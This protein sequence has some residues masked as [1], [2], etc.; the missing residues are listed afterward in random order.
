NI[1]C[2]HKIKK[3]SFSKKANSQQFKAKIVQICHSPPAPTACNI[4][5]SNFKLLLH[6]VNNLKNMKSLKKADGFHKKATSFW[7]LKMQFPKKEGER[8]LIVVLGIGR[9]V[10]A[11]INLRKIYPSKCEFFGADPFS[12][13]N[14]KLFESVNGIFFR[15]AIG[16]ERKLKKAILLT[17]LFPTLLNGGLFDELD[18]HVCQ[19]SMELH[20]SMGEDNDAASLNFLQAAAKSRRS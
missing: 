6:P 14:K 9:E 19:I 2:T 5:D 15:A 20:F 17:D 1:C 8:C 11:E 16:M 10:G 13:Y 18:M 7:V 4:K 3:N 12:Q